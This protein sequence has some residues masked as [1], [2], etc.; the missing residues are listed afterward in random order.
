MSSCNAASAEISATELVC[1]I[2]ST[3]QNINMMVDWTAVF[4]NNKNSLTWFSIYLVSE[5][6]GIVYGCPPEVFWPSKFMYIRIEQKVEDQ[7]PY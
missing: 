7:F 3:M 2:L 4:W 1:E 6:F 5:L